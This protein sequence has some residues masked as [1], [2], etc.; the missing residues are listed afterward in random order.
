MHIKKVIVLLFVIGFPV[1]FLCRLYNSDGVRRMDDH[2]YTHVFH[3][4]FNIGNVSEEMA[5]LLDNNGVLEEKII[6]SYFNE[7]KPIKGD[8]SQYIS[9]SPL[10]SLF[11]D[12]KYWGKEGSPVLLQD[13]HRYLVQLVLDDKHV[14]ITSLN[15]ISWNFISLTDLTGRASDN[16]LVKELLRNKQ[17]LLA[18]QREGAA[19]VYPTTDDFDLAISEIDNLIKESPFSA[20]DMITQLGCPLIGWKAD[21][22]QYTVAYAIKFSQTFRHSRGKVEVWNEGKK[23]EFDSV[24]HALIYFNI[25]DD[26]ITGIIIDASTPE[27]P[28]D[29][30][31]MH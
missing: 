2:I 21:N 5:A 24:Y 16:V 29:V 13:G 30:K 23:A 6:H 1:V 31:L 25:T 20:K 14:K 10:R 19:I 22:M 27:I 8:F 15:F 18:I 11:N 3:G 7:I 9:F 28:T 12:T 26:V 4:T 17:S